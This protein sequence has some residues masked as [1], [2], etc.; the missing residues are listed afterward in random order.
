ME[1]FLRR[2]YR[3]RA[4]QRPRQR[5]MQLVEMAFVF[6]ILMALLGGITELSW[7]YYTSATLARATRAGAGYIASKTFTST[8]INKA[9]YLT[10]CG[11]TANCNSPKKPMV[12]NLGINNI[13]VALAGT[14]PNETVTVKIINYSYTPLFNLVNLAKVSKWDSSGTGITAATTMRY[15]GD[16]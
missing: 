8:E 9:K 3:Y 6:P 13:D 1:K 15:T 10:L 4:G 5:G 11:E 7:Y 16:L 12:L 2:Q 14:Y